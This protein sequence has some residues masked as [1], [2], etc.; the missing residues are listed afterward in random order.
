MAKGIFMYAIVRDGE[1]LEK[2][3]PNEHYCRTGAAPTMGTRFTFAEYKTVWGKTPTFFEPYTVV[4]NLRI[5]LEE[6]R[7]ETKEL[8]NVEIIAREGIE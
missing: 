7:W 2:I 3:E 6:Y 1:Y 8:Q 4:N 5:L